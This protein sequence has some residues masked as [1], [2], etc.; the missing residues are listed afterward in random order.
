M[1]YKNKIYIAFDG[2]ND[3]RYYD[4]MLAWK[5]QN[6]DFNF[7]NAHDLHTASDSSKE[8]SIKASLRDRFANSKMFILIIGEHTKYLTKFVKWEIETAIRLNLPIVAVNINKS[9]FSDELCPPVLKNQ[10]AIF[11]PFE[12]KIVKLAINTWAENDKNHRKKGEIGN[13][14]Y[15]DSLYKDLED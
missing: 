15:A 12:R 13:F 2:D 1:A 11:V 5:A 4:L 9:R 8:E 6:D 7:Y 10:L 14:S 3:I